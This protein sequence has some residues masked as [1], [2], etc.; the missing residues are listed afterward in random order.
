MKNEVE[1]YNCPNILK[2][3]L[4]KHLLEN[5]HIYYGQRAQGQKV[6][7]SALG[8]CFAERHQPLYCTIR[9]LHLAVISFTLFSGS[10]IDRW[11]MEENKT[12]LDHSLTWQKRMNSHSLRRWLN[13]SR[14]DQNLIS[15]GKIKTASGNQL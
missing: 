7:A 10:K 9:D 14:F 1:S 4:K 11:L 6:E 5:F 15:N 2:Y 12:K 8:P 13:L 3:K